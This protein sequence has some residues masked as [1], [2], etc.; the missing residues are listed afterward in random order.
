MPS[1]CPYPAGRLSLW[2]SASQTQLPTNPKITLNITYQRQ[3][4]P[5]KMCDKGAC[6][7]GPGCTCTPCPDHPK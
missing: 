5:A 3:P 2:P 1:I 4:K 6:K 7:C